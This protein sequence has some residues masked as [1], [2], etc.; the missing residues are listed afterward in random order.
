MS[1]HTPISKLAKS[2]F[3]R[4]LATHLPSL[5]VVS[6]VDEEDVE[7]VISKLKELT[8]VEGLKEALEILKENGVEVWAVSNG[9]FSFFLLRLSR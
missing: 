9:A 2:T 5:E 3:R 7:F 6:A 1:Q 8:P 4:S